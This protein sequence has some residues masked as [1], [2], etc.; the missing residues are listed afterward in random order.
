MKPEIGKLHE[1]L[2]PY[3]ELTPGRSRSAS[4]SLKL[5][6]NN[7]KRGG[8]AQRRASPGSPALEAT[9]RQSPLF[10]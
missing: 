9:A 8:D 6:R 3:M 10:L 7:E 4:P 5:R 1:Q 2:P